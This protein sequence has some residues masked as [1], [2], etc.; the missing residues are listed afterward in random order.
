[1]AESVRALLCSLASGQQLMEDRTSDPNGPMGKISRR[2]L[3]IA[4]GALLLLYIIA[5]LISINARLSATDDRVLRVPISDQ[6]GESWEFQSYGDRADQFIRYGAKLFAAVLIVAISALA[7]RVFAPYQPTLAL[8]GTFMLLSSAVFACIAAML[9]LIL[10]EGFIGPIVTQGDFQYIEGLTDFFNALVPILV[11]SEKV[12]LTFAALGALAYGGLVAWTGALPRW[13]GW[14][15][16]AAG[17][18]L[19]LTREESIGLMPL[20]RGSPGLVWIPTRSVLNQLVGGPCL[21]W[22]LLS[23]GWLTARGTN[24]PS[25]GKDAPEMGETDA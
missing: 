4:D 1:M 3:E 17:L 16:M 21:A 12:G 7:Y 5:I 20:D 19:L 11:L 14:L 22:L 24:Y 9:G 2:G 18:L 25:R 6:S 15:G 8:V 13:L 10:G 23:A